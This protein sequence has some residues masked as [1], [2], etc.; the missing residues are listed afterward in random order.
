M[1]PTALAIAIAALLGSALVRRHRR[2][3][4]VARRRAGAGAVPGRRAAARPSP[5]ASRRAHG[6]PDASLSAA[7]QTALVTTYCATC[8]SER[9]KAG[10]LSLANFNAMRA[11]EQPEVVEKMIRKLRAGMMPPAG[12][13]RP[14]PA[15][16]AALTTALESRM[17]EQAA[18]NPNPG[19]RPFQRLNRAEYASA[20]KDLLRID[21]DVTTF[22]PPDTISHGFD[23]VADAQSFSPTL[24][25]GYLRAAGRITT[26]AL[27]DPTSAPTEATYKVPRTQ[28]QMEHI[29]GAPIGTRGG[30]S[31]VHV[32]PA[33]GEYSFRAM[34]HSIPTGQ[35]YGSI[36][37]GEKLEISIN[38]ERVALLDIN[39]R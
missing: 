28:S 29:D 20:V 21:V 15:T 10:G 38:G 22:L 37:R 39:H 3:I 19:W 7:D 1:K 8:H 31:L 35:L 2:H 17:D 24:M 26:L 11:Q 13:K 34:L 36:V 5:G 33:D 12:A 27:G 6:A 16:I 9:A 25:E 23:N 14:E 18:A 4:V 32:F 30:V